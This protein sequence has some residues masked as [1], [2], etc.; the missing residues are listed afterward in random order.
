MVSGEEDRE[1]AST[2]RLKEFSTDRA[3]IAVGEPFTPY[4]ERRHGPHR[5]QRPL[6]RPE[7]DLGLADVVHQRCLDQVGMV[8]YPS[9]NIEGVAL[10]L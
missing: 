9:G 8:R 7:M 1:C 5:D 4:R 2:V 10:I 3:V 6:D